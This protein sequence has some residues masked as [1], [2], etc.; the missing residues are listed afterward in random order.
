[1]AYVRFVGSENV[2]GCT[3]IPETDNVV[4][5]QFVADKELNTSGFDLFL[6]EECSVDIGG[7]YYHAFTTVYRNDSTTVEYNGYELSNDGSVYIEPT[8]EEQ[9]EPVEP[10][11]DEVKESK[12]SEL[13]NVQQ[14]T[15]VNGV[16]VT[17]SDGNSHHFSLS[18]Y[19]QISLMALQTQVTAG[20]EQIPWHT[21]DSDTGCEYF[22]NADMA[23]IIAK[24]LAH[25]TWHVTYFINL[26]IYINALETVDEVNAIEYGV[27][28]P[29]EYQDD[30]MKDLYKAME[31]SNA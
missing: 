16:D 8:P 26:K 28:I 9:P 1:M 11:L 22:S 19:D 23:T 15:I 30:V 29:E 24:A 21:A 5:M 17:L 3:V 2:Y 10:T 13:N 20:V 7:E 25:V 6:D 4:K 18:E 12:I 14:E 31:K 27:Y